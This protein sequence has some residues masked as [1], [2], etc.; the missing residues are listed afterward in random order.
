MEAAIKRYENDLEK[1]K[2][3]DKEMPELLSIK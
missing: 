1:L 2:I 3:I